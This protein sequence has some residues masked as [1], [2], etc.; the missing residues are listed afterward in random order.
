MIYDAIV[1]GSGAS[2][3]YFALSSAKKNKKIAIIEKNNLGGTAFYDGCLPVK[4]I[5]DKIKDF[6]KAKALMEDE[7]VNINFDYDLLFKKAKQTLNNTKSFIEKRLKENN[8]DIYYSNPKII[9]SKKVLIDNKILETKKIVIATG[10]TPCSFNKDFE[11][12]ERVIFSHKGILK[13]NEL[14][15]EL[16]ILGANVEGVEFAS[17]FSELDVQVNLIERENEILKGNDYD[18]IENIKSRL[19]DNNVNIIL[20]KEVKNIN[21]K[22]DKV[23]ITFSDDTQFEC[24]NI[25]ITG[26][27]K[28]NIPEIKDDF[29]LKLT[30]SFIEVD[31]NLQTNIEDIYAIGDVNGLHGMAHIAVQQGILLS[32][33]I[34]SNKEITFDYKSLPRC[35]FTINELAGAGYQENELK[36]CITKKIYFKESFRGFDNT[37]DDGFI[38]LII[39]DNKIKGYFI[40]S[41]DANKMVG[42]IGLWIDQDVDL[43]KIKRTLFINPTVFEGLL[44]A[45]I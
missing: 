24:K 40:N 33:Y 18:L 13:L 22:E 4:K 26:V 14:P 43:E 23:L 5:M 17:M 12:D 3:I 16:T 27:R 39:K 30:N 41:I 45:I 37:N 35:I 7:L 36:D 10:T 44:D 31:K 29:S 38:K 21:K 6:N 42:N 28:A 20:N 1:I 15:K 11:I 9:S 8:I 2:G 32:D 34:Y 19:I 25:L